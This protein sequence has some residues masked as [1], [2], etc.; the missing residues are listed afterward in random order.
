MVDQGGVLYGSSGATSLIPPPAQQREGLDWLAR[1]Q[2][3]T[4][5]LGRIRATF[6]GSGGRR[7]AA[8]RALRARA[9]PPGPSRA[10]LRRP[11]ASRT[12]K[13]RPRPG[14]CSTASCARPAMAGAAR[15]TSIRRETAGAERRPP[16]RC[17]W[18]RSW[19][20]TPSSPALTSSTR[21]CAGK[22]WKTPGWPASSASS[23]WR[24]SSGSTSAASATP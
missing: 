6:D 3:G 18:P 10:P 23:W 11:S 4:L 8:H 24:S 12:S 13:D 21:P 19:D 20:P 9:R 7:R 22:C 14:S 16:R 2:G 1:E 17:D 5:D 15:S